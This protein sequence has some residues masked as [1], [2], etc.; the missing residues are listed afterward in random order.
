MNYTLTDHV[1]HPIRPIDLLVTQVDSF[2]AVGIYAFLIDRDIN[3]GIKSISREELCTCTELDD[4]DDV[5]TALEQLVAAGLVEEVI[6]AEAV[7][8]GA[9]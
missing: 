6:E 9:V 3:T 1:P 2:L 4:T 5:A 7:Q 8:G